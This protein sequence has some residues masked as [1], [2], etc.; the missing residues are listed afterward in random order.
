MSKETYK[1]RVYWKLAYSF[2]DWSMI[3]MVVNMSGPDT[4]VIAMRLH[5]IDKQEAES[6]LE[7][8]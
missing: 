7:W 5:L 1:E 6:Q 4:E 8:F 2:R 3:I